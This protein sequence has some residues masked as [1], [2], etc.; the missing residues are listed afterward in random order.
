MCLFSLRF[1]LSSFLFSTKHQL[2]IL[3]IVSFHKKNFSKYT[4]YFTI[5][6]KIIYNLKKIIKISTLNDEAIEYITL[7][8]RSDK[9]LY[10]MYQ[11][12]TSLYVYRLDTSL[13]KVLR[14]TLCS[15][16]LLYVMYYSYTSPYMM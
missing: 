5:F 1:K 4:T 6:S 8:Y 2:F 14:Y 16:A 15:G 13:Y 7:M 10:M 3:K 11:S 12:N 9:S